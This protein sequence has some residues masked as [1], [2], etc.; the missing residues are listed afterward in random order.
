VVVSAGHSSVGTPFKKS[1]SGPV[2]VMVPSNVGSGVV[3]H[4]Y[5]P[6]ASLV[7]S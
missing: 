2:Q 6:L 4:P 3:V 1:L 5:M 7:M